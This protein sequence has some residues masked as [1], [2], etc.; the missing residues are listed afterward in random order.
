MG[1]GWYVFLGVCLVL[2]LM[3]DVVV[4]VVFCWLGYDICIEIMGYGFWV[5]VCMIFY[6]ELE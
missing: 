6:E 5:M 3:S 1:S 2:C 4:N